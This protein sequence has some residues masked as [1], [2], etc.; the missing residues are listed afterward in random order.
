MLRHSQ[1]TS[2]P[3]LFMQYLYGIH[4]VI[5]KIHCRIIFSVHAHFKLVDGGRLGRVTCSPSE[6]DENFIDDPT[7]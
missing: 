3:Q 5:L 4:I 1:N 2:D 7:D 6:T